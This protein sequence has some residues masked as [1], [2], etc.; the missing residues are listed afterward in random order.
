MAEQRDDRAKMLNGLDSMAKLQGLK[1][2]RTET[3]K[4]PLYALTAD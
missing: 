3:R 2:E 1:V 4:G